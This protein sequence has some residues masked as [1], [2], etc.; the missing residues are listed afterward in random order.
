[1]I[2]EIY[3]KV[4]EEWRRKEDVLTG[5]FF[6]LMRYSS[7]FSS[8]LGALLSTAKFQKGK[9]IPKEAYRTAL[10]SIGEN[11]ELVFWEKLERKEIDLL[12]ICRKT[13]VVIGIEVK[14]LSKL[15]S[16]DEKEI[17]VEREESK[18]Q[19]AVYSR[20]MQKKYAG[21]KRFLV[22]LAKAAE[23]KDI[24]D[25]SYER[26]THIEMDGFGY[27]SWESFFRELGK[28]KL[29]DARDRLIAKDLKDYLAHKGLNGFTRF[30]LEKLGRWSVDTQLGYYWVAANA[31]FDSP[32]IKSITVDPSLI[33]KN[34][35]LW[36]K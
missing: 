11:W 36:N 30:N 34:L 24:Y 33:F 26:V 15:S 32:K 21:Y 18:N 1:M 14:Y 2:A 23:A 25:M 22:F 29:E 6:G 8:I 4:P 5:S 16:D 12:L 35:T 3:N 9:V 28:L 13:K 10:N 19:L 31:F 27:C 20:L 7:S 17:D